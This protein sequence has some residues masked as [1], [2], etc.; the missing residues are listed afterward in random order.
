V[1]PVND[2]PIASNILATVIEDTTTAIPVSFSDVD[3]GTVFTGPWI[4]IMSWPS[5][6][7]VIGFSGSNILY[8]P[9][10]N[11]YGPDSFTYRVSDSYAFGNTAT[12]SINV[13]PVND[14]PVASSKS[15]TLAEDTSVTFTVSG[16]DV[17]G[18]AL[19]YEIVTAPT[20]GALSIAGTNY[21]Y[22]PATNFF[23]NDSFTFRASDGMLWSAPATVS[24][25]VT[26]VN[27]A[28]I[29]FAQSVTLAEDGSR[30]IVLTGSDGDGETLAYSIVSSPSHGALSGTPPNVTYQPVPNYYGAD[31]FTFQVTDGNSSSAPAVVSITVSPIN[32][33][34][35][36]TNRNFAATED[37]PLN[38]TLTGSDVDGDALTFRI[39]STPLHGTITGV[40]PEFTYTPDANYN[41]SDSFYYTAN[42]GTW[43]GNTAAVII[44]I[45]P[46]NDAPSVTNQSIAT[47]EDTSATFAPLASDIDGDAVTFTI[48][49]APTNGVAVVNGGNLVYTPNANYNGTD[50]FEYQ[51]HDSKGGDTTARVFVT[52][53]PVN[54][55][56]VASNGSRTLAEDTSA[57]LTLSASDVD[58]DALTFS[59]VNAPAHGTLSGTG[60]NVTY[61]P[62]A[63]YNGGDSFT[64][65]TTDPSGASSDALFSLTITPVN[66]RPVASNETVNV[67]EETPFWFVPAAT[68]VDGDTIGFVIVS[69]PL[70]GTAV[71]TNGGILYTPATNYFGN[72][73][74]YYSPTDA[75][76]TGAF[77]S[78]VFN[79]ANVNDAPTANS[80]TATTAEDTAVNIALSGS[81]PDNDALIFT[82]VSSPSHGT[83][84][85][86]GA[87][88]TYTPAANYNGSDTFTFLVNDGTTNSAVATVSITVT[89]VNDPPSL[90]SYATAIDEDTPITFTLTA[91]DADNDPLTYT[92]VSNPSH[93]TL[94]GTGPT[95]TYTPSLNYTGVDSM[96]IR[97]SDGIA[98]S[99]NAYVTFTMRAV[100][101]API[102]NAQSVSVNED[103]PVLITLAG[104]DV[105]GNLLMYTLRSNPAH[106]TISGAAL[107]I[108][109]TNANLTYTPAANYNGPDSFTFSVHDGYTNS[110]I[111]TVTIS[112]AAV[113]DAPVANTQ[114][115]SVTY[116]M[117]QTITLTGS[118][119][120][121]S[122]LTY[123]VVSGPTN[124]AL[125]GTAPNLT[126]T[127]NIGSAGADF[128]TFR[129]N[130]GSL[131]SATASVSLTTLNPT[132]IPAA[133]SSL[134]VTVPTATG[135]LILNWSCTATNE[136]GFKIERSLNGS[137]GWSQIATTGINILTFTNTGLSSN[138]RYYYR[139]RSYNRLGDSA[140]S[141]TANAKAR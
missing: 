123:T 98:T 64:F 89:P 96:T 129:V 73:I 8:A 72:D 17:D 29:A 6:G 50:S 109:S 84:S 90:F 114:F 12:V 132:G 139:V 5:H 41:G 105:D 43:D 131:N 134:S 104:S 100:N 63:N 26:S 37:M 112:V 66:D 35:V 39:T 102:A 18:D 94:S 9:T 59:I 70:H 75:I 13:T 16:S 36:V 20:N 60:A 86:T 106:G 69:Q 10:A 34:P 117:A 67:I 4:E 14:A 55:A 19:A 133:P 116:N 2:P 65:R 82:I 23:G 136:D 51:A 127:P 87:S 111:A 49:T 74:L 45:A 44:T 62:V 85:G 110:A 78:V 25:T 32:D 22:Y 33:A 141:N 58:G 31:S 47:M 107:N 95:F 77:V 11:Y 126:Y 42:D 76:S 118:D 122:A 1:T 124:G 99:G 83:L 80:R 7:D 125:S 91:S 52:V 27:D 119:L 115:V 121:G 128:F 138:T 38:F 88:R 61:M 135:T 15:L 92:I 28:P 113:N 56:P 48:F 81:D 53:Q 46:V 137:S 3:G 57:A 108:S 21:T 40:S 140:Y 68:D 30:A 24:I 130:D 79:I 54:D 101:D 93:G 103:T 97:A 71:V 120:E